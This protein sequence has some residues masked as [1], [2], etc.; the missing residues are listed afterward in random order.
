MGGE[1]KGG[2]QGR[3]RQRT[4]FQWNYVSKCWASVCAVV[5]EKALNDVLLN[6][7]KTL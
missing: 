7:D 6:S 5:K 2:Q 3:G 1:R 4:H